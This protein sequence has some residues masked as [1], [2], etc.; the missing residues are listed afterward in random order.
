MNVLTYSITIGL[1]DTY[2]LEFVYISHQNKAVRVLLHL[3]GISEM[4]AQSHCKLRL[5]A[6]LCGLG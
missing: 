4:A 6:K 1:V 2:F 3:K 5:I